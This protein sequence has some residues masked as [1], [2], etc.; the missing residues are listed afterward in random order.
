MSQ[1]NSKA[2]NSNAKDL[3]TKRKLDREPW[4]EI[5]ENSGTFDHFLLEIGGDLND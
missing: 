3:F 2:V 5:K 4:F 1:L